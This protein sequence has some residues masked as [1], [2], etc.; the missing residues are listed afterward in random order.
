MNRPHVAGQA[1]MISCLGMF[2]FPFTGLA[3]ADVGLFNSFKVRKAVH[4][5]ELS[6]RPDLGQCSRVAWWSSANRKSQPI[7]DV[8]KNKPVCLPDKLK[9]RGGNWKYVKIEKCIKL[10]W[11]LMETLD[12]KHEANFG[13]ILVL[14]WYQRSNFVSILVLFWYQRW[15][16]NQKYL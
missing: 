1:S 15:Y 7:F 2:C 11:N 10:K 9:A 16:M 5:R 4:M 14:F 8:A 12:G 13:S 6:P 3:S